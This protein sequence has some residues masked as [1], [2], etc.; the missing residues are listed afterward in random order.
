MLI[1]S[2]TVLFSVGMYL[3]NK[4]TRKRSEIGPKLTKKDTRTMSIDMNTQLVDV[5][6]VSFFLTLN[7]LFSFLFYCFLCSCFLWTS[8][9]Q[10][11]ILLIRSDNHAIFK[12]CINIFLCVQNLAS[13]GVWQYKCSANL[14]RQSEFMLRIILY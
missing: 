4:N 13:R 9:C 11:G 1:Y 5:S 12:Y 10:P 3:S 6:L 8:K 2:E 14:K 7:I